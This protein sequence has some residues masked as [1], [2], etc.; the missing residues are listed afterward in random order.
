MTR[1]ELTMKRLAE[2]GR[3]PASK[4]AKTGRIMT[5]MTRHVAGTAGPCRVWLTFDD[6]PDP[7]CTP[8]ILDALDAR[9]ARATFFVVGGRV[10]SQRPILQRAVAA[11][12]R[13]GNHTM[14]HPYLT[15]LDEAGV[16]AELETTDRL[17]APYLQGRIFRPPH[18]ARNRLVDTVAGELGYDMILWNVSVRDFHP[19]LQ[20]GRWVDFGLRMLGLGGDAVLLMHDV[21]PG[22][23]EHMPRFLDALIAAGAE[24]MPP[25][26]LQ[27]QGRPVS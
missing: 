7:V 11:G 23:A 18:G 24:F 17:L 21:Y 26:T 8:A 20:S 10:E 6:G 19:Q 12:H 25:E 5:R 14:T 4:L 3:R 2:A 1:W 27:A 15:M 22:T 13:I 16:R 9:G